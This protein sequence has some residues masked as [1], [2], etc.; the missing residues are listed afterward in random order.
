MRLLHGFVFVVLV[1]FLE[2]GAHGQRLDS[3]IVYI[4]A[5]SNETINCGSQSIPC[6]TFEAGITVACSLNDSSIPTII[7]EPGFYTNESLITISCNMNI[8]FVLIMKVI[9]TFSE[10]IPQV[11]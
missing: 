8:Q 5:S 2:I 7:V 3:S 9:F 6:A 11:N 10:L 4:S 1:G